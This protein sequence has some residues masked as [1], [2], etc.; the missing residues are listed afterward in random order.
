M[1]SACGDQ[2][3]HVPIKFGV[4][5][6]IDG[7]P[8]LARSVGPLDFLAQRLE[9]HQHLVER[10]RCWWRRSSSSS[11]WRHSDRWWWHKR[12]TASRRFDSVDHFD[13]GVF[14]RAASAGRR[15]STQFR[16]RNA[17]EPAASV[18][19]TDSTICADKDD[20]HWVATSDHRKVR[21]KP[22]GIVER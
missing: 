22:F 21:V 12:K 17:T 10:W 18:Q 16:G 13:V 9:R 6:P 15:R 20:D 19:R 2:Q 4:E 8:I 14:V 1:P 5:R 11:G 3:Y 7:S